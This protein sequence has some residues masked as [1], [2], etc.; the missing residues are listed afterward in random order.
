ML[1]RPTF[2]DYARYKGV[3]EMPR[4]YLDELMAK[5]I[6]EDPNFP[7]LVNEAMARQDAAPEHRP[8]ISGGPRNTG[9]GN[10]AHKVARHVRNLADRWKHKTSA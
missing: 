9:L 6:A 7:R 1:V 3:C 4:D 2:V 5:G 10:S 8:I